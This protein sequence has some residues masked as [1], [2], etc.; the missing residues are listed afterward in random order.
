M[1]PSFSGDPGSSFE[2]GSDS[3]PTIVSHF[4]L[5]DDIV[6]PERPRAPLAAYTTSN[7]LIGRDFFSPSQSPSPSRPGSQSSFSSEPL[8]SPVPVDYHSYYLPLEDC[9]PRQLPE[10][11]WIQPGYSEAAGRYVYLENKAEYDSSYPDPNSSSG[12]EHRPYGTWGSPRDR[13]LH[14]AAEWEEAERGRMQN[15]VSY[16]R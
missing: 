14:L 7:A 1:E 15:S 13:A 4:G 8:S 10:S 3:R 2:D 5:L 12:F 16:Y 11:T 6:T 9:S